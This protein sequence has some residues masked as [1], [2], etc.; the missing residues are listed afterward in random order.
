MFND[1]NVASCLAQ[2]V[3]IQIM[4]ACK[5]EAGSETASREPKLKPAS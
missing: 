4:E 2:H 5:Q 1:L 3:T